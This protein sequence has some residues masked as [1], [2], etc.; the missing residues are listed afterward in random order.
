MRQEFAENHGKSENPSETMETT[1]GH[2]TPETKDLP[3]MVGIG[4]V[5]IGF[6]GMKRTRI[7]CLAR[8]S[9]QVQSG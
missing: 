9:A 1:I 8:A 2:K 4:I 6:M 7:K 3:Q 5:G